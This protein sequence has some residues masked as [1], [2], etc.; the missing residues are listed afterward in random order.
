MRKQ[1][2]ASFQTSSYKKVSYIEHG[3][4]NSPPLVRI[5]WFITFYH[6]LPLFV[7][8][9]ARFF[10]FLI[11]SI[12]KL[13]LFIPPFLSLTLF[14]LK[15]IFKHFVP[16]DLITFLICFP[17]HLRH[18]WFTLIMMGR[19]FFCFKLIRKCTWAC[20]AMCLRWNDD[21]YSC[22]SKR[23]RNIYTWTAHCCR[24]CTSS[25]FLWG[26]GAS[27]TCGFFCAE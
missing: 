2:L 23:S 14:T 24:K 3:S 9:S 16:N 27:K 25:L 4:K 8:Y 13:N 19:A 21:I 1:A 22:I 11:F 12:N 5:F 20:F 15:V 17:I 10:N 18:A 6:K 26:W 7:Y